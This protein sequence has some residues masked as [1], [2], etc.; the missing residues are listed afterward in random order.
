MYVRIRNLSFFSFSGGEVAGGGVGVDV[1]G[2][3]HDRALP[4]GAAHACLHEASFAALVGSE[5]S[6][7]RC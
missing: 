1:L 3:G 7:H 4:Y 2:K 5:L 6:N